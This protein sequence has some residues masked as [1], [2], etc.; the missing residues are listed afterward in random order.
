MSY[1]LGKVIHTEFEVTNEGII[2]SERL[3]NNLDLPI[4]SPPRDTWHH[5]VQTLF[6][7]LL[8]TNDR[9]RLATNKKI[10]VPITTLM[11]SSAH[12]P[13]LMAFWVVNRSFDP[14]IPDHQS[15]LLTRFPILTPQRNIAV[16]TYNNIVANMNSLDE[17]IRNLVTLE[18]V[19]ARQLYEHL[20]DTYRLEQDRFI[21]HIL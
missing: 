7:A 18:M 5:E 1:V 15:C 19:E 9:T 20:R 17:H 6:Q 12:D 3:A 21:L 14:Q 4:R 13:Q 8:V 16:D 10:L 2:A 11:N